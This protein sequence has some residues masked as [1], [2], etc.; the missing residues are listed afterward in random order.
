ML[1]SLPA[2]RTET[3]T[4]MP[5]KFRDRAKRR[6]GS[7]PRFGSVDGFLEGPAFDRDGNLYVMDIPYRRVFRI[8]PLG[9]WELVDPDT[10]SQWLL[11]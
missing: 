1:S 5:H 11:Q 8:D 2:I 4:S 9:Q 10:Q 7:A 3:F 6:A